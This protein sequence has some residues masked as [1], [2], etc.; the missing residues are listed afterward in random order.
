MA[1]LGVAWARIS[2]LIFRVQFAATSGWGRR[3]IRAK[4]ELLKTL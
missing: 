4:N 2:E 1:G 3:P